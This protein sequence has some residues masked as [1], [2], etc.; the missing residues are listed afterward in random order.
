MCSITPKSLNGSEYRNAVS[1]TRLILLSS[2]SYGKILYSNIRVITT[3]GFSVARMHC[4][5][6]GAASLI[7]P[8]EMKVEINDFLT[9]LSYI[10]SEYRDYLAKREVL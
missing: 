1:F 3:S 2:F 5:T 10:F 4:L 7:N 6:K 9:A 8:R